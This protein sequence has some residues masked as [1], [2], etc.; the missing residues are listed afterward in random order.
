M[1]L[2]LAPWPRQPDH[3]QKTPDEQSHYGD[4]HP[5]PDQPIPDRGRQQATG[6]HNPAAEGTS[7]KD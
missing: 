3:T 6:H 5:T 1:F 2:L 7:Y 4:Q